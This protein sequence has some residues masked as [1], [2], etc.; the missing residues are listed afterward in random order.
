MNILKRVAIILLY[1]IF[2]PFILILWLLL[3]PLIAIIELKEL[4]IDGDY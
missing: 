2:S 4:E 1:I 3:L